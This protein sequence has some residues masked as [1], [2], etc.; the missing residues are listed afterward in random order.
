M[1]R[2]ST[3]A[4]RVFTP[5]HYAPYELEVLPA[6]PAGTAHYFTVTPTGVTLHAK[7]QPAEL[8][9]MTQWL[10]ERELFGLLRS[11]PFFRQYILRRAF[12]LWK[13]VRPT[14]GCAAMCACRGKGRGPSAAR[15]GC[16]RLPV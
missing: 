16:C 15:D 8:T 13:T 11:I 4:C 2:L 1:T 6:A 14:N 9:P 12:D 5:E 3:S 7:G 10:R